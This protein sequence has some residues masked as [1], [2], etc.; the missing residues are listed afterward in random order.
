MQI[1]QKITPFLWFDGNA[2]EA[3]DFY[4]AAFPD[5]RILKVG[6][7]GKA[8]PG[9]EGS[10]MTIAFELAGQT[11]GAINGGPHFKF[12]GA[13][14]LFVDCE[15]QAEIDRLWTTLGEGGEGHDCGWLT[16]RFG[17]TWQINSWQVPEM[18]VS[19]TP[20]QSERAMRAMMGMTKIDLAAIRRAYAG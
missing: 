19:G 16:D 20:A 7:Y 12:T 11:F 17:L 9:P 4:V 6:R 18:I 2:E 15:T 3:V 5:S 10:V 14:S 1:R 8:G 13:V